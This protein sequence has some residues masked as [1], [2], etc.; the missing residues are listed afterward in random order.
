MKAV[1]CVCFGS[2]HYGN[3]SEMRSDLTLTRA[4]PQSTLNL[5]SRHV[6][7]KASIYLLV[8]DRAKTKAHKFASGPHFSFLPKTVAV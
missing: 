3:V 6:V 7:F 8:S 5:P 1:F 2:W 4:L